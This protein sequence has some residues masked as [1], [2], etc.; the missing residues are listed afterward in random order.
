M[1]LEHSTLLE[2]MLEKIKKRQVKDFTGLEIDTTQS[3]G[4]SWIKKTE[5]KKRQKWR[6]VIGKTPNWLDTQL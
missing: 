3:A 1:L 6:R 4:F 5:E 2:C